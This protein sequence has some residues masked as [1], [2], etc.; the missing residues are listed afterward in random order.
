MADLDER[1]EYHIASGI[2]KSMQ[3]GIWLELGDVL[4]SEEE[5]TE[6]WG[7]FLLAL[8]ENKGVKSQTFKR[9]DHQLLRW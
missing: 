5:G 8:Y 6:P 7:L 1:P 9:S 2:G 4:N 3:K